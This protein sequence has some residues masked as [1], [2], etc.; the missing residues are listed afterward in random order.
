MPL[1]RR[2]FLG[3]GLAAGL[4]A[5]TAQP[6]EPPRPLT[7]ADLP[8]PALLIDLAAFEAN[9]RTMAEHGK[10]AGCGLRPHAK[11][12]KCP[13]IARRQVAAGALG[14]CVA[15]VPEAEAMVAAG[16]R[17]VLLTSPVLEPPKLARM[18]ALARRPGAV[19]LAVGHARQVELLVEAA[20]AAGVVVD[21]LIDVD[22]GD[23]RTGIQP[24][25]PALRLAQQIARE[26]SLRLR[27]VQAYAGHASHA[28]GFANRAKVSRAAMTLAAETRELLAKAGLDVPILSGGSTGTYNIDSA[29]RGVTEL[30]VGS[31]VFMDVDYRRIGGRDG[32]VYTDFRPSLTVLTTVVSATHPDRVTVDAG[33]KAFST[34][35][36]HRPEARGRDGL[37]YAR[38]GDE[39]GTVT[40]TK[41]AM[42]PR[43][44]ERLAFLVPHCDPTVNLYDRLYAMRGDRVEAVWP[45]VARRETATPGGERG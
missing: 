45:T 34:D 36:P 23:R 12:H 14:V 37:T 28:V 44:G 38:A 39:F 35:G 18:A 7:K 41:G 8:T 2:T 5:A 42:L 24:G 15:T 33:T 40:A 22:V 10:R 1:P 19:L 11:T 3:A 9:L 13:E 27:G 16:V 6:H 4:A 31:Y 17:G 30:Q 25:Q 43:L 26:R 32:P 29:V 21:V 20:R